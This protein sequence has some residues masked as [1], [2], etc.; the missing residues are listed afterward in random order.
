MFFQ[1]L[2]LCTVLYSLVVTCKVLGQSPP[3]QG[4]IFQERVNFITVYILKLTS[5]G[6]WFFWFL[7]DSKIFC[8]PFWQ[9]DQCLISNPGYF[10]AILQVI[11]CRYSF[12]IDIFNI[13]SIRL[14]LRF[15]EK[16]FTYPSCLLDSTSCCFLQ[17]SSAAR[18]AF[19]VS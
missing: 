7:V 4:H 18:H 16:K 1:V 10:V 2:V 15:Q 11:N 17:T 3:N 6:I 8:L 14:S 9:F 13:H 12:Q 5:N 19:L